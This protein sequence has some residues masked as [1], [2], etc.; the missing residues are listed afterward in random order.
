[1]A[2]GLQKDFTMIYK[3]DSAVPRRPLHSHLTIGGQ[4]W[5][6]FDPNGVWELKLVKGGNALKLL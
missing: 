5:I 3:V 6:G 1:M 4:S 2:A